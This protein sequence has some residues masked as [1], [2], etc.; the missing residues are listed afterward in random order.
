M[1]VARL[2]ILLFVAVGT[3]G[4]SEGL[5]PT[6]LARMSR[7]L[8]SFIID[9]ITYFHLIL[10][11]MFVTQ[12]TKRQRIADNWKPVTDVWDV[13]ERNKATT[14]VWHSAGEVGKRTRIISKHGL[15]EHGLYLL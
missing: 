7:K 3:N 12:P 11:Q 2:S 9:C 14:W 1:A 13:V 10:N 6:K 5:Q 4:T 8:K 15:D